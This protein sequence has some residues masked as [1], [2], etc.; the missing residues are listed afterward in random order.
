MGLFDLF[1]KKEKL[2][3][4]TDKI[5][6]N[7]SGKY[8]GLLKLIE[9]YP[10][11]VCIS[12]FPETQSVFDQFLKS[13]VSKQIEIKM[14]RYIQPSQVENKTVIFLEHYPL[15]IE[16]EKLIQFWNP[17]EIFVLSSLDEPLFEIFGG[18]RIVTMMENMG[19]KDDEQIQHAM[20]TKSIKRAQEK[21]Q[22]KVLTE[23]T[24]NSSKDWF[25]KN[26]GN[27]L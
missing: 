27:K 13:S 22:E 4:M 15:R 6:K 3:Q 17:N 8:G 24:A 11:A 5:W 16:E 23:N 1:S 12:W 2:P 14:A 18:Q 7:Q 9:Q 20:I 19:L 21:L 10:D 26:M 25:I